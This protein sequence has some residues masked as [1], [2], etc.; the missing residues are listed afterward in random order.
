MKK[1]YFIAINCGQNQVF[2]TRAE[3]AKTC[4][5]PEGIYDCGIISAVE[6]CFCAPGYLIDS[7]NNCIQQSNCGCIL[8]DKSGVIDVNNFF[9]FIWKFHKYIFKIQERYVIY[10]KRLHDYLYM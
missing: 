3:C 4:L 6:G 7:N 10:I 8:P 2:D 1:K 9:L 5:Y